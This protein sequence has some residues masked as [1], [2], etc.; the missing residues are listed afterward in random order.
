MLPLRYELRNVDEESSRRQLD[1][2]QAAAELQQLTVLIE[3][4]PKAQ[5]SESTLALISQLVEFYSQSRESVTQARDRVA[6]LAD[7]RTGLLK[8]LARA[9]MQA[10]LK[11][12]E[13]LIDVNV[14]VRK[15]LGLALDEPAYRAEMA[16]SSRRMLAAWESLLKKTEE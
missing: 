4:I 7:R 16:D 12:G 6:E 14:A 13:L 11:Y 2:Q 3:S 15:E 1:T 10:A 8:E 5:P 9:G